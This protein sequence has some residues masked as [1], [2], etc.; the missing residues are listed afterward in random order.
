[1]R[2]RR[3]PRLELKVHGGY[4]LTRKFPA[5]QI[6]R[7]VDEGDS[8]RDVTAGEPET[9]RRDSRRGAWHISSQKVRETGQGHGVLSLIEGKDPPFS[10]KQGLA[11]QAVRK[12]SQT[13]VTPRRSRNRRVSRRTK[14]WVGG[15]HREYC[16]TRTET[17]LHL[18]GGPRTVR[19][20]KRSTLCC[21][22]RSRTTLQS[23]AGSSLL[24]RMCLKRML[25]FPS[26]L[27]TESL[28][29]QKRKRLRSSKA[30]VP[31]C[32]AQAGVE[33]PPPR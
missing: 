5:G 19:P 20:Q 15:A 24:A 28:R 33:E 17:E 31:R 13:S 7:S 22:V 8:R 27:G 2:R 1:M 16:R 18:P 12:D 26:G 21:L 14:T 11:S 6:S 32:V 3:G 23:A 9:S 30:V 29:S 25:P 10:P 4:Q